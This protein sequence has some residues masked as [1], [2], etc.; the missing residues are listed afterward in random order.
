MGLVSDPLAAARMRAAQQRAA[1]YRPRPQPVTR[2]APV[3]QSRP[4]VRQRLSGQ[5][6]TN[7]EYGRLAALARGAGPTQEEKPPAGGIIG[8]GLGMVLNNPVT[9]T[10]LR[11]LDV[12]AVPQRAIWS[13]IQEAKDQLT[14]GDGDGFSFQDWYDQTNP[15]HG[16]TQKGDPT[17]GAGQVIPDVDTPLSEG[18]D[19]WINRGIGLTGDIVGDPLTYVAGTGFIGKAGTATGRLA[20]AHNISKAAD[21]LREAGKFTDE[22]RDALQRVGKR[23]YQEA[24]DELLEL[25][26]VQG[27]LRF[28]VPFTGKS[29]QP[30]LPGVSRATS[31]GRA[32]VGDAARKVGLT[33]GDRAFLKAGAP[34]E[35][36]DAYQRIFRGEGP[37]DM[38]AATRTVSAELAKRR[39]QNW[40]AASF[41]KEADELVKQSRK[42]GEEERADA[43]RVLEDPAREAAE[44]SFAGRMRDILDRMW[45]AADEA[46]VDL[47]RRE[48]YAP[49]ILTRDATQW[50]RSSGDDVNAVKLRGFVMDDLFAP[51]GVSMHRKFRPGETITLNDKSYT[52]GNA[53][54]EELNE[55]FKK[56]TGKDFNFYETDPGDIIEKYINMLSS[57]VGVASMAGERAGVVG[58]G[59]WNN[60]AYQRTAGRGGNRNV[61]PETTVVG[62]DDAGEVVSNLGPQTIKG[63]GRVSEALPAGVEGPVRYGRSDLDVLS[64]RAGVELPEELFTVA[65]NYD[66]SKAVNQEIVGNLLGQ[67]RARTAESEQLFGNIISTIENL[68]TAPTARYETWNRIAKDLTKRK[69][70]LVADANK[71]IRYRTGWEAPGNVQARRLGQE[72]SNR[73]AQLDEQT[74]RIAEFE[75]SIANIEAGVAMYDEVLEVIM[76]DIDVMDA[77][78]DRVAVRRLR[79]QVKKLNAE[80]D[81]LRR[82]LQGV[83]ERQSAIPSP[84]TDNPELLSRKAAISDR[85][86][87]DNANAQS[88]EDWTWEQVGGPIHEKEVQRLKAARASEVKKSGV[89]EAQRYLDTS[90]N[91]A[92]HDNAKDVLERNRQAKVWNERKAKEVAAQERLD[93]ASSVFPVKIPD[94]LPDAPPFAVPTPQEVAEA[95]KFLR[96]KASKNVVKNRKIVDD[97]ANNPSQAMRT[98]DGRIKAAEARVAEARAKM[99]QRLEADEMY[100]SVKQSEAATDR[101]ATGP[102]AEGSVAAGRQASALP[103][104]EYI[105]AAMRTPNVAPKPGVSDVTVRGIP[106]SEIADASNPQVRKALDMQG[107]VMPPAARHD[108]AEAT[109]QH[110]QKTTDPGEEL[111]VRQRITGDREATKARVR[112]DQKIAETAVARIGEIN[113]SLAKI[114]GR[115]PELRDNL[116]ELARVAFASNEQGPARAAAAD[117]MDKLMNAHMTSRVYRESQ[118]EIARLRRRIEKAK[119]DVSNV[120]DTEPML[121]EDRLLA[122]QQEQSDAARY[123]GKTVDLPKGRGGGG[124]PTSRSLDEIDAD[125][126][127]ERSNIAKAIEDAVQQR[128]EA[129]DKAGRAQAGRGEAAARVRAANKA[130]IEAKKVVEGLD[131]PSARVEAG[132]LADDMAAIADDVRDTADSATVNLLDAA[133]ESARKL[134]GNDL[135]EPRVNALINEGRSGRLGRVVD[136][137]LAEGINMLEPALLGD[138]Y[139]IADDVRQAFQRVSAAQYDKDFWPVVDGFTNFFKTYATLS[140]GFHF[141]NGASAVFMNTSDGV[142]LSD[143]KRGL[144]LSREFARA[145][146]EGKQTDWLA[147]RGKEVL[148]DSTGATIE[149]AF[150]AAFGS[151]IGGRYRERGFAERGTL[152]GKGSEWLYSNK[153]AK[154]SQKLGGI[155]E[156]SVR[157]PVAIDTLRKGGSLDDAMVRINRLHFDYSQVSRLDEKAR[158]LVPFWTFMSRNLPLQ[159]SQMWMKPRAY[160]MYRNISNNLTGD[161][162]PGTPEYFDAIG[163][164]RLGDAELGGLPVFLQPDLPHLRLGEDLERWENALSGD[165]A[166]AL[167]DVNPFFTTPVEYVTGKDLFTGRT[168]DED[169]VRKTGGLESPIGWFADMMGLG[170]DLPSGEFATD[171][172][173]ISAFRSMMPMYDRSLRLAPGI[174]S[175][176]AAAEQQNRQAESIL[177]FLGIPIRQL[178]P[179][180]QEATLRGDYYDSVREQSLQ[181]KLAEIDSAG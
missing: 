61:G 146:K 105:E 114:Y 90:P 139:L 135:V 164:F 128:A 29:T 18:W 52:L 69:N 161:A 46:G 21:R 107:D 70:E 110:I 41:G 173:L 51:A 32:R 109:R 13:T 58:S 65:K 43:I 119:Q 16:I 71:Q 22:A 36:E 118:D 35:L 85:R 76:R 83:I 80:R 157:L 112:A 172:K 26:D 68:P 163:A 143:Q 95:R 153:L 60:P 72:R 133:V 129:G 6:T 178:S 116:K 169:D 24:D 123:R 34:K 57:D 158:K 154:G 64:E 159:I 47:G 38:N 12:L 37:L 62:T 79:D 63:G 59:I 122:R 168:Y 56:A 67:K 30:V 40:L 103:D 42:L 104:A 89:E 142:P 44:G 8:R 92:R 84:W 91:V 179:Q 134:D 176:G 96:L 149:D 175:G 99:A 111:A 127:A 74:G 14:T 170:Q 1:A 136:L 93:A 141:R 152:R 150:Q 156:S 33:G 15:F 5:P 3:Q 2:Q 75:Q 121:L 19:K 160:S 167:T 7:T 73:V 48:N 100:Q 132:G 78:A 54:V 9:N 125:L 137:Q 148:N 117:Q 81:E 181:R 49:H 66:E 28:G 87:L 82:D 174:T 155:V 115:D 120:A 177:R 55:L 131:T 50:L 23:G 147:K 94:G 180:Q 97:F 102:S 77:A 130:S 4:P 45:T 10:L 20:R 138:R 101:L 39:G 98:V 27:G 88:I 106:L 17:F 31:A 124:T 86:D 140:P 162:E 11:P 25:M 151:G 165:P 166:Q 144:S 108:V 126:A 113:E 171:E 145:S 53:S